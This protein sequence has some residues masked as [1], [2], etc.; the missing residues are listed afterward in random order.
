MADKKN[1]A[2]FAKPPDWDKIEEAV[3]GTLEHFNKMS[4]TEKSNVIL[5]LKSTVD[6][7]FNVLTIIDFLSQLKESEENLDM[8]KVRDMG[9]YG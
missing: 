9:Q 4:Y 5:L 1:K 8:E 6:R 3:K 7:E 2:K